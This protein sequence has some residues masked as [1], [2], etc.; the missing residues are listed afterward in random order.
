[1]YR[2]YVLL[3]FKTKHNSDEFKPL[4]MF[5]NPIG[6]ILQSITIISKIVDE[7]C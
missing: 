4:K 6:I 7:A 1:M 5:F 3:N 2:Y